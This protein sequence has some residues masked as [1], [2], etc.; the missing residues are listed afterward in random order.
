[1]W[2]EVEVVRVGDVAS[3]FPTRAFVLGDVDPHG[4]GLGAGEPDG[5]AVVV[6]IHAPALLVCLG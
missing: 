3:L 1:V 5:C 6:E 2:R 4:S